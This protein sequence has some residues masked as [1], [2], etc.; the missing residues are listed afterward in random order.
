M[1][2][3]GKRRVNWRR[4]CCLPRRPSPSLLVLPSLSPAVHLLEKDRSPGSGQR[5]MVHV[6][7]ELCS[8]CCCTHNNSRG[9]EGLSSK[10]LFIYDFF[11]KVYFGIW[12]LKMYLYLKIN[13]KCIF[14]HKKQ[15]YLSKEVNFDHVQCSIPYTF[16]MP[17][18]K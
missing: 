12:N 7:L 2:V 15:K 3:K 11:Y 17:L 6:S 5:K 13:L 14:I 9:R 18:Y 8:S 10:I 16:C 4:C 1:F